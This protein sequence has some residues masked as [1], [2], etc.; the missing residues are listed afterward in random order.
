MATERECGYNA[1][2]ADYLDG[3]GYI[4]EYWGERSADWLA[5]YDEG[6]RAAEQESA[7]AR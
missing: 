1:G 7:N 6:Q 3:F 5:G 2:R 4:P